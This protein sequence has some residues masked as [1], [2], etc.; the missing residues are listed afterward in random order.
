MDKSE[1]YELLIER[2]ECLYGKEIPNEIRNR[3]LR[4]KDYLQLSKFEDEFIVFA[5]LLMEMKKKQI[6]YSLISTAT[7]S[8]L[9]YLLLQ[10]EM[11]PLPPHY[12]C[13]QCRRILFA[14]GDKKIRIGIDLPNMQ[15][16][17]GS[18]LSG[19]GFDLS[20]KFFWEQ[21]QLN[22]SVS[23]FEGDYEFVKNWLC[24]DKL[25]QDKEIKEEYI[26]ESIVKR[27][28]IGIITV[29]AEKSE[30]Y[31]TNKNGWNEVRK[32]K[33]KVIENYELLLPCKRKIKNHPR[34]MYELIRVVAFFYTMYMKNTEC[35]VSEDNILEAEEMYLLLEKTYD[36]DINKVPI[37][38]EDGLMP[39]EWNVDEY[40]F[41]IFFTHA[42]A[43]CVL[44]EITDKMSWIF[45]EEKAYVI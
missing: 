20:E 9:L 34:N 30:L 19:E 4:E 23:V 25:M 42:F 35:Y 33:K 22:L 5:K 2:M 41:L 16:K 39:G 10:L 3:Y 26:D 14:K 11:N 21:E 6:K 43:E 37:F 13:P 8:F 24:K 36:N 32:Y 12:Y 28:G 44:D 38:Q 29:L 18:E 31:S 40:N 1:F 17:C 7:H 45:E 15:C 27:L